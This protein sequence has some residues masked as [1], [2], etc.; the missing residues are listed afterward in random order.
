MDENAGENLHA[1]TRA[2]TS[3]S[4]RN[5]KHHAGLWTGLLVLFI[6]L[7]VYIV[8]LCPTVFVGDAGDFLTAAY[9]LGV[10]HPP[11]Y[12]L[13]TMLGHVFMNL[14]I[15]GGIS[16]PAYRMN[17][18]SAIAGWAACVFL[19][20][21]LRRVI[22]TGW[23]A[24]AGTL[25][26]AFSRQFWQH[27]AI[28]EVYTMELMFIALI[29]YLAVLYVQDKKMG[30]AMLLAFIMGLALSHHYAVLIF[31]PGVFIF[32]GANGGLRIGAKWWSLAVLLAIIGLLPYAYLPIVH[33]KSPIGN[34]AFVQSAEEAEDLPEGTKGEIR[35]PAEY[36]WKY[37]SRQLYSESRQFTNTPESLPERTTTPMVFKRF[38]EVTFEDYGYPLILI[39]L[40]GWFA[41]IF[42]RRSHKDK[43]SDVPSGHI[44]LALLPPFLG[45]ILYFLV[46]HFYPSGDILAAPLE[47]IAVVIPPLL[48]PLELGF[49]VAIAVGMNWAQLSIESYL[50]NQQMLK[51]ESSDKPP[52]HQPNIRYS[53]K[54]K[55][56]SALLVLASFILVTVQ[57]ISNLAY[58]D[59]SRSV[60]SYFY[61]LNVLDS[62][63]DD[64][65]LITTGDETFLFWYIQ[66]CEPSSD[67]NDAEP[68]YRKD[69]WA[70]NWIHNIPDL[71]IL[72]DEANAMS[73]VTSDFIVNSGYYFPDMS[74]Y[75]GERPVNT[76]FVA[77]SFIDSPV[78]RY[79][80][81]VLRG[82]TYSI[83]RPG[84]VPDISDRRVYNNVD[85]DPSLPGVGPM[86]VVDYFD[87]RPF[88]N[89]RWEGLPRFQGIENDLTTI[90]PTEYETVYLEPQELEV[91][92]RYQDTFYRLGVRALLDENDP[93]SSSEAWKYFFHAVSLNPT[94]WF[95]WKELGDA[96]L[97]AGEPVRALEAYEQLVEISS[98][99]DVG[100][101][102]TA[103]AM[104]G[105]AH[106][107]LILGD[108]DGSE[109][110]ARQ[111]LILNPGE[112]LA[113]RILVEIEKK[114]DAMSE[115]EQ[116]EDTESNVEEEEA[117]GPESGSEP[118]GDIH[119]LEQLPMGD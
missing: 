111:A 47:N 51:K 52:E 78:I 21:Y 113:T 97:N 106:V 36:F 46:V 3:E 35:T 5:L 4:P 100:P 22:K 49:A 93:D 87:T 55:T 18:M 15:P 70:T 33:Y 17:L 79:H 101:A 88:E 59:K 28:A 1:E 26:L 81:V 72:S 68:G 77:N 2:S 86:L 66:A 109:T 63:D 12:P 89:F 67:P 62:C 34:I 92:G 10:P 60:I 110:M 80:D 117:S 91:L 61:A 45:Y 84:D 31:Y 7:V 115:Q 48:L 43:K 20:L 103:G 13:Y 16:S 64:A 11:G 32:I 107:K 42:G 65:I 90:S 82:L 119:E 29:M 30:W 75:F 105:V 24:L 98:G 108:L 112:S 14:P 96:L 69:V 23:A 38:A 73:V 58:C 9:T 8:T 39:A 118:D 56:F 94:D 99:M 40:L 19:F 27:A 50:V 37:V 85:I 25:A 95:G 74:N 116:Q 53:Q 83:R 102:R 104:A 44:R 71:S 114:R 57:M 76:T 54:Y 6:P 41:V